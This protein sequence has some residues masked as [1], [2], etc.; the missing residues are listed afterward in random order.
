MRNLPE[1]IA[2]EILMTLLLSYLI[3]YFY[4]RRMESTFR[5]R[6]AITLILTMMGSMLNTL[7]YY[8]ISN[9]DFLNTVI[10]VNISMAV[11]SFTLITLLWLSTFDRRERKLGNRSILI[12]ALLLLY[13]EVSMGTFVYTLGFGYVLGQNSVGLFASFLDLLSLG[14]NSYLFIVPMVAEMLV[15]FLLRSTGGSHRTVLTILIILSVISPTIAGNEYFVQPGAIL[16]LLAMAVAIPL[17][18]HGMLHG[19][20]D[21]SEIEKYRLVWIFPIMLV[22]M[23]GVLFGS[24]YTGPYSFS[25]AIYGAGMILSM[26][27]YFAFSASYPYEMNRAVEPV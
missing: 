16:E 24:F 4:D 18:F 14:I 26:I 3:I 12:F 1:V 23:A 13:N 22:M 11:M 8:L 20:G 27:F 2:T 9:K 17:L 21:H 19:S 5:Q 25:W 7:A 15:V 6:S 10:A